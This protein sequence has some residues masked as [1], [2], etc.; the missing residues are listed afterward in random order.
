MSFPTLIMGLIIK[1]KLKL[2]SGLTILPRDYPIGAH[3]MTRSTAHIRG[4]KISLPQ[5]LRDHVEE[6][7]GDTEEEI[8]RFTS[9]LESSAQP[10]FQAQAQGLDKLDR[11]IARVDQMFGILDSHVQH[12]VD[13][14]AYI[15]GQITELSSQIDDISMTKGSDL[16]FE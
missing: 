12:T 9:A 16:E 11:H 4:S 3:T 13:Q 10:S 7:G 14:F 1:A 6:E 2:S 8:E 5:I 15:Q